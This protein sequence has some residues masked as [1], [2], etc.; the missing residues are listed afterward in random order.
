MIFEIY[1]SFQLLFLVQGIKLGFK[2]VLLGWK[3]FLSIIREDMVEIYVDFYRFIIRLYKFRMDR[4]SFYVE[5]F[6]MRF[7]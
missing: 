5:I 2:R 3:G 1:I 4:F 6:S 7:G